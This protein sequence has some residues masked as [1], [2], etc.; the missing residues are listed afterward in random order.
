MTEK[1]HYLRKVGAVA[2]K[3][4]KVTTITVAVLMVIV[5]SLLPFGLR[6]GIV[7]WLEQKGMEAEVGYID[8]RPILGSIQINDVRVVAP[9]GKRLNFDEMQL[10]FT[11]DSVYHHWLDVEHVIVKGATLDIVAGKN[12]VSVAGIEFLADETSSSSEP[13][14][15]LEPVPPVISRLILQELELDSLEVCF[16]KLN[17]QNEKAFHQC[18]RIKH[19]SLIDNIDLHLGGDNPSAVIPGITLSNFRWYDQQTLT[20]LVSVDSLNVK[21][22][23]SNHMKGW[24]V[25]EL[26]LEVLRVLPIA[27]NGEMTQGDLQLNTLRLTGLDIGETNKIGTLSLTNVN[28]DLRSDD[29]GVLAF[30]PALMKTINQLSPESEEVAAE[31][32]EQN[33]R[34]SLGRL[35]VDELVVRDLGGDEARAPIPLAAIDSFSVSNLNSEDM[36]GWQMGEMS[37]GELRILPVSIKGEMTAGDLQLDSLLLSGLEIGAANKIDTLSLTRVKVELQS[38]DDGALVFA[39]ALMERLSP[40][41]TDEPAEN[42]P[43]ASDKSGVFSIG[44]LA[45]NEVVIHDAGRDKGLLSFSDFSLQQLTTRGD[46][47]ELG[48][49][50]MS[51]L[52][53]L[54]LESENRVKAKHYFTTPKIKLVGLAKGENQVRASDALI[55]DPVVFL[56]RSAD[57]G[58][59]M[60]KDIERMMGASE[61]GGSASAGASGGATPTKLLIG[62]ITIGSE[63][64]L[65]VLD[66]SVSPIFEQTFTDL[67]FTFDNNAKPNLKFNLGISKFGHLRFGGNLAPFGNKLDAAITGE[68]RGLDVRYLS[69][70]AGEYIGYHLDQGIGEADIAFDV[71][72]DDIDATITARFHKLEVSPMREDEIPEGSEALGVP[73]ELA[74]DLLRDGDGMIELKLPIS[75]DIHSPDF[76]LRHIITKVM[77]KVVSETIIN[78]YIPFGLIVGDT[79]KNTLSNLNFEPVLF[80]PGESELDAEAIASL[81]K[82]SEMLNSRQQLHFSLC[83]PSTLQDWS[84]KFSPPVVPEEKKK[85]EQTQAGIQEDA[86]LLGFTQQIPVVMITPEQ[87][88]A[89]KSLANQRSEAVK[90]HLL[91]GGVQTGQVIPCDAVFDKNNKDLPQMDIAL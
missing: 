38:G 30:A 41:S 86:G 60:L 1:T 81:D 50:Q 8:I 78:Y 14:V 34:F 48:E 7:N 76:S 87:E 13:N 18:A 71:N 33:S 91:N 63:G 51:Q 23:A 59:V 26:I 11:W 75:G 47:L 44:R 21:N 45:V 36:T 24:Q 84:V 17:D 54:E 79:M 43:K 72:Q 65:S 3:T 29:D 32:P 16:A 5:L 85:A 89:L 35:D 6:W 62:N 40:F 74:L 20:E 42:I 69:A 37:M 4:I 19:L 27:S 22:V 9:D 82:L 58:L 55:A 77:F 61:T 90:R 39:P 73:L 2:V 53:L 57:G 64:K 10:N 66:E 68:L 28:V 83:A 15:E 67:D 46:T 70:Y 52:K 25:D 49:L 56:H 80:A 12:G 88:A 31:T